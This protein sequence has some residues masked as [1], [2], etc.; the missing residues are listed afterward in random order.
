MYHKIRFQRRWAGAWNEAKMVG[1][2][3]GEFTLVFSHDVLGT[4]GEEIGLIV[5]TVSGDMTNSEFT[6]C[7]NSC[8]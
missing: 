7:M 5:V 1:V 2:G 6:L 4:D 3:A 8:R